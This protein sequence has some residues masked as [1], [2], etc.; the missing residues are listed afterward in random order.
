MEH[1][2]EPNE[3]LEAVVEEA[4][5]EDGRAEPISRREVQQREG[6]ESDDPQD[7]AQM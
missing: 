1:E 6:S 2:E 3:D 4:Q 5:R 7:G